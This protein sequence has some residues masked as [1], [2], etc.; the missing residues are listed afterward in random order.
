M[1]EENP[2]AFMLKRISELEAAARIASDESTKWKSRY[3]REQEAHAKLRTAH[4]ALAKDQP[5][6]LDKLTKERDALVL[7][8]DALKGKVESSPSEWK[9]KAEELQAALHAR[10]A[11]D[12]WGQVLGKDTLR[13]KVT[14]EK[15]WAEIDYK[16]G[17]TPPTP[18][19]ITEQLATARE[20]VPYLFK[21]VDATTTTSTNGSQGSQTTAKSPLKETVAVG[22]G[23]PDKTASRVRVLKSQLQDPAWKLDKRNQEM[24]REAQANGVLD[25]VDG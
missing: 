10:D 11:K 14:V 21:D 13:D 19:E 5:D 7:E 25:V 9:T 15:L 12:A 4:D 2:N 16:P 8:R 22:R 6:A 1:S 3:R 23:A 24:M 17:D 20:S 18:E